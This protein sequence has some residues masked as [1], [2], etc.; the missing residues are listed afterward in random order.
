MQ[1]IDVLLYGTMREWP[2]WLNVPRECIEVLEEICINS[3]VSEYIFDV[4]VALH[5]RYQ[6]FFFVAQRATLAIL[7]EVNRKNALF[8]VFLHQKVH[9]HTAHQTSTF[10]DIRAHLLLCL[11]IY[12]QQP[13]E[14]LQLLLIL[15][16]RLPFLTDADTLER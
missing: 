16:W 9:E 1:D 8:S 14:A 15:S 7:L 10:Y 13:Q 6:F 5:E 11:A 2:L 12:K 3:F 4:E